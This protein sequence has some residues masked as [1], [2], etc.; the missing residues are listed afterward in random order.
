MTLQPLSRRT[1]LR[2]AGVSLAIPWLDA[3]NSLHAQDPVEP[4]RRLICINTT[5]GLHTPNLFPVRTGF[6]YEVTPYLKHIE[7]FRRDFTVFSGLSH[8]DVNDSHASEFVF[9]TSAI[10]PGKENF[11]NSISLDQYAIE[12][13]KPDTRFGALTLSTGG[14]GLAYS[15]RGVPIPAVESPSR[16]F[17]EMFVQGT[18][19]EVKAE[20]ERL[21]QGRSILDV[22]LEQ[23]RSLDKRL[24]KNDS[25][26]LDEYFTSVR[27]VEQRL[28]KSQAWAQRPKPKAGVEAP[29]DVASNIDVV[30]RTRVM[31][32]IMR[33]ALQSDSTRFITLGING[34]NAVLP[35]QGM[36]DEWHNLSHH[37]QD[38][39]KIAQLELVENELMRLFG[40]L[41]TKLSQTKESGG[42]LLD[43]TIVLFGSN[44]GN[45]NSH[46]NKNMPIL[47]AGGGFRH[48]QHVAFDPQKNP[49][50]C[51][52]Y[53]QFLRRLGADVN[54]FGSS[55][56]PIPGFDLA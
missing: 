26:K 9:L 11:K 17:K 50:L 29:R 30:A 37:G 34:L 31:L 51:N 44:L 46:D 32:E 19:A 21:N 8:P 48:G 4:P 2:G 43:R 39:A 33:L 49:P 23:A 22:L 15:R 7:E 12:V 47:V 56:G 14:H 6:D 55:T 53:V 16:I 38:P 5:F 27:E 40:E 13:L 18:P 1:F 41:L 28:L 42:C 24:G 3:M 36:K 54:S 45:G 10:H 25:E 35:I 20:V 52:L